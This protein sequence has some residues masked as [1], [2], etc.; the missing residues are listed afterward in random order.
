MGHGLS[1]F[2]TPSAESRSWRRE[3]KS[4]DPNSR[5]CL[6]CQFLL[7]LS[8]IRDKSRKRQVVHRH[9]PRR[10]PLLV[11]QGTMGYILMTH[12][13]NKPHNIDCT[14]VAVG[15][16]ADGG[17]AVY[18]TWSG[19]EQTHDRF[20]CQH[21]PNLIISL[22]LL[23][24]QLLYINMNIHTY[25]FLYRERSYI[26]LYRERSYIYNG[27]SSGNVFIYSCS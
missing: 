22:P 26:S 3:R 16:S 23:E 5:S 18:V 15:Y 20:N 21:R 7:L 27:C 1:G 2:P 25:I 24:G 19:W 4:G 14:G 17:K 9:I 8:I 11:A 10:G 13:R 6:Y 12:S